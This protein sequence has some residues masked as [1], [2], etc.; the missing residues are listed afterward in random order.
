M[1][2]YIM[3]SDPGDTRTKMK[4]ELHM[5]KY[6]VVFH[7]V[8]YWPM[9]GRSE[10]SNCWLFDEVDK[11]KKWAADEWQDD[12]VKDIQIYEYTGIQYVLIERRHRDA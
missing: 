3:D 2:S 4:G 6:L 7:I 9:T 5:L 10:T 12:D 8:R 1:I 11:A